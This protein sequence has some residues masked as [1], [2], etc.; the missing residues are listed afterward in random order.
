MKAQAGILEQDTPDDVAA[1][2]RQAVDD[3]L[4][5]PATKP[6]SRRTSSRS[7]GLGGE[8]QLGGD[9]RNEAFS[10]WRRFLEGLAEQ[11]PLVLV[12]EDLH[13]ADESLLDFV[14]EL[15]DWL[16]DVPLLV[17]ATARPELLERRPGWG[18][19]KLNATTLALSPLSDDQTAELIGRLLERPLL[20]AE[21][22]QALLERAGGNPLYAEQFVEL[23][24]EQGSTDELPLPETLQGII[25]A[26]LDG[27]PEPEKELLQDAA[28]V[29]KVF[30]ASSIGRRSGCRHRV[31]PLARA[32]GLRPSP[33]PLVARGRERVRLR[34]RARP[35]RRRTAR[36]RAP[37]ARDGIARSRSGSTALG[38]PEDHAEMLA[39]HWSSALELV[40]AAGGTDDEL[41]E[42]TRLALRAAGDRAF[43]LNS[44]SVAAAQYDE[45]LELWP[46]GRRASRAAVPQ[47]T[48]ALP[49][50]RRG[51]ARSRARGSA[52][53]L[54]RGRG[55]RSCRGGR[56]VPRAGLVVPGRR[57]DHPCPP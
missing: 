25:A 41:A 11:R 17:V 51:A 27:L 57:R 53:R 24:V 13:W 19:G 12:F 28:V 43:A 55:R 35:R 2:I 56:V 23:Y 16:T 6:G 20:A 10:A 46:R 54:A 34:A 4:Q 44:F 45:A 9:R 33:A 47:S 15:V 14:D 7:L 30:W 21:S 32:Q 38:R 49:R 31:S 8:A 39:Y 22:Q 52:R 18:G 37:T 48:R 40:R 50:V 3:A 1:K 26:R 42:R 29:G 5:A 36:S